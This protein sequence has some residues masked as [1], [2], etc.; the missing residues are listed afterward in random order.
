MIQQLKWTNGK[1]L[2]KGLV[3][4]LGNLKHHF[5]STS[6]FSPTFNNIQWES[7]IQLFL[8]SHWTSF[9]NSSFCRA[10]IENPDKE[11]SIENS[12]EDALPHGRFGESDLDVQI[13]M[14]LKDVEIVSF[15][16]S[17]NIIENHFKT[18]LFRKVSIENTDREF[19]IENYDEEASQHG[20][21]KERDKAVQKMYKAQRCVCEVS[22]LFSLHY[23]WD[24]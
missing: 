24:K 18:A 15:N 10:S 1:V 4:H 6:S 13:G 5:P 21:F 7:C 19:R 17:W 23:H 9:E 2:A 22:Q 14:K 12:K 8:K 3:L 20:V 11:A 16:F